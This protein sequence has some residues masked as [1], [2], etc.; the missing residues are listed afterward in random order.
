MR[1]PRVIIFDGGT[2]TRNALKRFF[3][4]RGYETVVVA[5]SEFCPFYGQEP[6][7][8]GTRRRFCCDIAVVVEKGHCMNGTQPLTSQS[9][10]CCTLT[11]HNKATIV[12]V[13]GGNERNVAA[14]TGAAVFRHPLDLDGF[15]AWVQ[16]CQQRMDLSI[17]LAIKR[18]APRRT[19]SADMKVRFRVL[20]RGEVRQACALN[21]SS[22]GICIKTQHCLKLREMIHLRSEKPP[23]SEDA[24]VR[25]IRRVEDGTHIIGLTFCVV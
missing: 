7:S 4:A 11:P 24:E 25:W 8:P 13:P 16:S 19:C 23:L 3:D 9:H 20:K 1:K 5:Q 17:P 14:A 21:L 15:D 12:E 6:A 2:E 22:C 18:T 10:H